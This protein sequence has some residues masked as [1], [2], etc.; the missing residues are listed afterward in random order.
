MAS[1]HH[2]PES[3]LGILSIALT[4]LVSIWASVKMEVVHGVITLLFGIGTCVAVFFI[5][6]YLK[7]KFP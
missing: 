6:R 4:A 1:H 3:G 5:Q 7:K 2:V